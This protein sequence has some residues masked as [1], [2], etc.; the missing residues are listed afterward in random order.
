[1]CGIVGFNWEDK[2]LIKKMSDSIKHRGPDGYGYYT[3]KN[4]SL[5]HRRLSII[6]LSKNGKQP[7]SNEE[8]NIWI[9]FNGEIYNYKELRKELEIKY[10][11][12]SNSD[13][14]VIIHAYEEYGDFFLNKLKGMFALAI[15][16]TKKK[17]ILMARDHLGIKPLYYYWNENNL[18]F[19]S[20]IKAI[21]INKIKRELNN[22]ALNEIL[23]NRFISSDITPFNKIKKLLPG[24]Y[25]IIEKEKL[26]INKFWDIENKGKLDLKETGYIKK[27]KELLVSSVKDHM[28]ADVEVGSFLSGGIDSSLI[29]AIAQKEINKSNKSIKTFNVYFD[30][31]S[32][33]EFSTKVANHINSKHFDISIDENMA[34]KALSKIIKTYDE[35]LIDPATIPTYLISKYAKKKVKVVLAGEGSDELFGGYEYYKRINAIRNKI[36]PL[37]PVLN[38]I[39]SFPVKI[40]Q[41]KLNKLINL[42]KEFHNSTGFYN[43]LTSTFNKEEIEQ[44][45]NNRIT[46]TKNNYD[47]FENF[48][49]KLLYIDTKTLLP[50]YFLMKADKMT[51]AQSIE[52]RVPYIYPKIAEY[53]FQLPIKMKINNKE[54]KYI[55]KQVA[56]EYLPEEIIKRKKQGYG[57]PINNWMQNGQI[58][59]LIENHFEKNKTIINKEYLKKV[60]KNYKNSDHYKDQLWTLYNISKWHEEMF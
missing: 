33:K 41:N 19:A 15:W 53:A 28:I 6:D 42:N 5:G 36:I 26:T 46:L 20:E 18:I 9:T 44:I 52:E 1:M 14:E 21:L 55:I 47:K 59:N 12:K 17:R 24:H 34:I 51:M 30:N 58:G 10:K 50:E 49:D 7:M 40:K 16:D 45:T 31:F 38:I 8:G 56:K 57:V 11:F 32:E 27:L 37:R 25:C 22:E 2:V 29:T 60:I 4:V 13:T 35:P 3:D 54:E 43:Q 48:I 23:Q 39:S